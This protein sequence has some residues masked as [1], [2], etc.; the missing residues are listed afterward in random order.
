MIALS[1]AAGHN[2]VDDRNPRPGLQRHHRDDRLV[3]DALERTHRQTLL[4]DV[5]D[6]DRPHHPRQQIDVAVVTIEIHDCDVVPVGR[7]TV[8]PATGVLGLVTEIVDDEP[9]GGEIGMQRGSAGS[10]AG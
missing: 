2:G 6:A 7:A 1:R 8:R 10:A 4:V 9:T 5:A 3:L